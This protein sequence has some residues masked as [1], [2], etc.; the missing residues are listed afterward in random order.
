MSTS[1]QFSWKEEYNLG[2][3]VIDKEHQQ[4]F[5]IV[6]R[7][8]AFQQDEKNSQWACQEGIKYFKTHAIQHF[9]DEETYMRSINYEGLDNHLRIHK[10]F[11]DVM[12]PAL[13]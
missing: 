10:D 13:E 3:E 12:L 4:L 9:S 8:L 6:N 7:L 1:T 5:R 2:V 11:R